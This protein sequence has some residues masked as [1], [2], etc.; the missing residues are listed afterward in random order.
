VL[1]QNVPHHGKNLRQG[2]RPAFNQADHHFQVNDHGMIRLGHTGFPSALTAG[3][4]LLLLD[5]PLGGLIVGGASLCWFALSPRLA[6]SKRT[7]DI[8][9]QGITRVGQKQN[10]AV[11][12]SLQ[13]RA[14][15][16]VLLN[17]ASKGQ[18]IDSRRTPN[19]FFSIPVRRKLKK[20]LKLYDKKAKSWLVWLMKSDIPSFLFMFLGNSWINGGILF[21]KRQLYC[22]WVNFAK[23]GRVKL[24][25][26]Y[27][28]FFQNI[29]ELNRLKQPVT[30]SSNRSKAYRWKC[31]FDHGKPIMNMVRV[32]ILDMAHVIM[33][34]Q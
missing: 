5:F 15:V 25:Q 22:R 31:K 2:N 6:T 14:K 11:P 8:V 17:N 10:A 9:S 27:S 3:V 16:S 4:L 20:P 7:I 18:N 33:A 30:P 34:A 26:R 13:A 12:A 32:A 23:Q 19:P 28:L 21:V 24:A 1:S 29:P